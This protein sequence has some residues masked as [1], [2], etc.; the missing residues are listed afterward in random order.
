[1][2]FTYSGSPPKP[3]NFFS[4]RYCYRFFTVSVSPSPDRSWLTVHYHELFHHIP[5]PIF[6]HYILINFLWNYF[7]SDLKIRMTKY[8]NAKKHDITILMA[9]GHQTNSPLVQR[10][11]QLSY[12][13]LLI[14]FHL[15]S[16]R[17][18]KY[19]NQ[20]SSRSLQKCVPLDRLYEGHVKANGLRS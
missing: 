8:S 5:R 4:H 15:R 16:P 6:L 18:M 12:H 7:N 2:N 3:P 17:F 9:V 1:M 19:K 20:C 14:V 13:C 11:N 10:I